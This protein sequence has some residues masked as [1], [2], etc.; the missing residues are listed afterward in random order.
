MS[1]TRIGGLR[2][3]D[4]NIKRHGADFYARIGSKGGST[5][6][7]SPKGFAADRRS[8]KDK[9]FGK[10]KTAIWAGRIG[11]L[12]SKRTKKVKE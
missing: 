10:E 8:L 7:T 4:A 2:A 5:P 3:A 12:R 6:T 1:G 9:L 11:G